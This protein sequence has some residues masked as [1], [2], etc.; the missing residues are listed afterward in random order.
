MARNFYFGSDRLMA[1]GSATFSRL[2]N[3][4]PGAYG[5]S[6]E[7]AAEYAIVN[8]R[9]QSA[10][11]RATTPSTRT[12]VAVAGKNDAVRAMQ[13]AARDLC[14]I[15]NGTRTVS[16]AQLVG[17][18]LLP[19]AQRMRRHVPASAPSVQVDRVDGR[20][21]T[22]RISDREAPT[23]TRKARNAV[24]SQ[25][26][27]YVGESAPSDPR[28]LQY[29]GTFSRVI[30]TVNFPNDVPSGATIWLSARWVSAR[31]ELSSA[32][33][34]MPFTLQGGSVGGFEGGVVTPGSNRN[35]S[36]LA[37]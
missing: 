26:F 8:E 34:A 14:M 35:A 37:A 24:A 30:A 18:G 6:E 2:I 31:G 15:I 19:R 11:L 29:I 33:D 17:L 10:Y 5:L 12:S 25:L 16:D 13:R 9:L 28:A 20:R 7:R 36:L 21:V 1:K 22:V 23:A 27:A 32:S 3:E 4:D